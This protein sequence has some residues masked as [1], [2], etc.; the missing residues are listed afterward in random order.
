LFV[1]HRPA[2]TSIGIGGKQ[3]VCGQH[4]LRD[5]LAVPLLRKTGIIVGK[6]FPLPR[7]KPFLPKLEAT[8][9]S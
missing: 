2:G 5:Y 4:K 8:I 6:T 7:K 3:N 9:P 1:A